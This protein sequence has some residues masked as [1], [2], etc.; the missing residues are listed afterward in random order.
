LTGF[1]EPEAVAVFIPG[2]S[3][4][5]Y[6]L[7]NRKRNPEQEIWVGHRAG[8]TGALEQ[9]GADE[10]FPI[11]QLD[12]KLPELL[13]DKH[14]IYYTLGRSRDFDN[15]MTQWLE[16]IRKE[17]RRG[18]NAPG[19]IS[20]IDQLI[21]EQRLIKS[22]AEIELMRKSAQISAAGHIR[23]MKTC[24]PGMFE[25][26]IEAELVYEFY[27]HG[28]RA[29]AYDSIVASDNNA[30]ILHYTENSSSLQSGSLL[31][32]DAAG[33]YQNYASDITRTFPINGQFTEAQ[34]T[35][36]ELVL[37]AQL[38]GIAAVKPDNTFNQIQET[39][40]PII[41]Q[42]L[43]ELGILKGSLESCIEK[44]SYRQFYMHN[45]S[46]WL[47]LDVH[48]VGNYKVNGAWRKLKPGMV[49]TVEPGIYI[50]PNTPDVDPKWCGMGIRIED[51][52]LVTKNGCEVLS[53]EAPKS[54]KDIESLMKK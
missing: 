17:V 43:L 9:Y 19:E 49:L 23:A 26:E 28:C 51:D 21:H 8:Q 22:P 5:E 13:R 44:Q 38:A 14:K 12:T 45:A 32:I 54:V 3:E 48:D 25:Y 52:V 39:I 6:I 30:C 42:G 18:V 47:G 2:R 24:R 1:S 41:T 37:K 36:Y 40:I 15:K 35:I 50:A 16:E 33:E 34:K 29:T 7:F 11:E 10:A 31:L 4:G 53:A 27:K 46:H 20:D